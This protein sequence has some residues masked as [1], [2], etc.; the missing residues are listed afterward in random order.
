MLQGLVDVR[1]WVLHILNVGEKRE[2]QKR[3]EVK[4]AYCNVRNHGERG[5]GLLTSNYG[6]SIRAIICSCLQEDV[7]F[8]EEHDRLPDSSIL[9]DLLQLLFERLRAG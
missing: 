8:I 4:K 5:E 1:L 9:K 6:V 7:G 3:K 2:E